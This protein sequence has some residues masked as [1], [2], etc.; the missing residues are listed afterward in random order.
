MDRD[1]ISGLEKGLGVI[2]CFNEK[3]QKMT[4][5]DVSHETGL[6]RAAARRCLLTLT[7]LDFAEYDGKYFRLT[8]KIL[9]LGYSF[10]SATDLPRI[11]QPALERLS[12]E[13]H[14]ACS[15]AILDG[16]DTVYI[17]RAGTK[18]IISVG[19]T[20]GARLPAY[21]TSM[22]RVLL[23]AL[24]PQVAR[25]RLAQSPRPKLTANTV[26]GVDELMEVLAEVRQ[27]GY[28]LSDQELEVGLCALAVPIRNS[29]GTTVAAM[30]IAVN[31][32][33]MTPQALATL[34]LAK[35]LDAERTIRALLQ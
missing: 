24:D 4:I 30:N 1:H 11:V 6:S 29:A 5:A 15:A 20:V 25:E 21:C 35:L 8:P 33:R 3:H 9:R 27:R 14:E 16:S 22:G 28:S 12:E 17:A 7:S 13:F 10:L 31:S 32:Q 23:A 19:L 26:T 34:S 2:E 18:R